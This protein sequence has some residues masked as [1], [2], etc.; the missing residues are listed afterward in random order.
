[1]SQ[2]QRLKKNPSTDA[3]SWSS[4]PRSGEIFPH[5]PID[6]VQSGNP[7]FEDGSLYSRYNRYCAVHK[8]G[9]F[10]LKFDYSLFST[11][12]TRK[13]EKTFVM[14][15]KATKPVPPRAASDRTHTVSQKIKPTRQ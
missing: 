7:T 9:H 4:S 12:K 15:R 13:T 5:T 14:P 1:M 2:T 3:P 8:F 11:S 10:S 6:R